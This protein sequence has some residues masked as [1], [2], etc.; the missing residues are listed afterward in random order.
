MRSDHFFFLLCALFFTKIKSRFG[1]FIHS[2]HHSFAS[3][4]WLPIALYLSFNCSFSL[5]F[6]LS[7]CFSLSLALF[8]CFSASFPIAPCL[9]S[10]HQIQLPIQMICL[11]ILFV[12]FC[13][14]HC[15][16]ISF[17]CN[18]SLIGRLVPKP[19]IEPYSKSSSMSFDFF[20]VHIVNANNLKIDCLQFSAFSRIDWWIWY[21]RIIIT[22]HVVVILL[23]SFHL[24]F[25][26]RHFS[27]ILLSPW[28][29]YVYISLLSCNM[30]V[31]FH[32][33]MPLFRSQ[34]LFP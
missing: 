9:S 31:I 11:V 30:T 6:S 5:S 29:I 28:L 2:F 18:F 25:H 22:C 16:A 13:C 34:M 23:F 17:V 14:H 27:S 8:V 32:N 12:L 1:P 21:R 20:F 4:V 3:L 15:A 24:L 19:R 33:R 10:L 7:L 26:L